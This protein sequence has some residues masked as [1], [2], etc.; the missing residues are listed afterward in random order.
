MSIL[1][2]VVMGLPSQSDGLMYRGD[3]S[4]PRPYNFCILTSAYM[5]NDSSFV[6]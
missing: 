2:E 6:L 3:W 4:K 5:N 1:L